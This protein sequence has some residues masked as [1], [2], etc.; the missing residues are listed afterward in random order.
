M[1]KGIRG[2]EILL[3]DIT[4]HYV[5]VYVRKYTQGTIGDARRLQPRIVDPRTP[6]GF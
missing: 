1:E 3:R 5:H 6:D 4:E 2:R